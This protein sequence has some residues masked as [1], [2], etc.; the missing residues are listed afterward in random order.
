LAC[1]GA[2]RISPVFQRIE[3]MAVRSS[4]RKISSGL[5]RRSALGLCRKLKKLLA[6]A[7]LDAATLEVMVAKTPNV[8]G[9]AA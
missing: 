1:V 8:P 4:T 2:L 5:Q 7:E 6:E 9:A 3:A